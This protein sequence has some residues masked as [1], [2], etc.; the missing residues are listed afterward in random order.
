MKNTELQ[1]HH[2]GL[3]IIRL[4]LAVLLLIHGITRLRLGTVGG[5]GEFLAS[6]GIP[7]GVA[8]AWFVTVFELTASLLM[9]AGRFVTPV[10]C[11]FISIYACGIWLVHWSQGW[12]VVGPG[13][14][15]MEYSV[16]IIACLSGLA[17]AHRSEFFK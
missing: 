5:F 17:W 12:F 13:T 8:V 15:G 1:H 3:I 7:F 9:A 6:N 16:L 4:T 2:Q 10:A 11:V 14:G